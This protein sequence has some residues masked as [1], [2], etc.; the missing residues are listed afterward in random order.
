MQLVKLVPVCALAAAVLMIG[1]PRASASAIPC[2]YGAITMAASPTLTAPSPA[3]PANTIT[4]SGGS[5]S[6]GAP[7]TGF[8]KEWLRDGVV[9]AGPTW[10]VGPPGSFAYTVQSADVGHAIRSAV[11]PCND[12]V[13]C[14][15]SYA[16]S[17]NSVTP[18]SRPPTTGDEACTMFPT[19]AGC[20]VWFGT[21]DSDL[22]DCADGT[23]GPDPAHP[24]CDDPSLDTSVVAPTSC[25][26]DFPNC[27]CPS[28]QD[29]KRLVR[30][31]HNFKM[32]GTGIVV[33]YY[34]MRVFWCSNGASDSGR[35]TKIYTVYDH[36]I[37]KVASIYWH[38][39][40]LDYTS[41]DGGPYGHCAEQAG[42][43]AHPVHTVTISSKGRFQECLTIRFVF[44]HDKTL[45]VWLRIH[46]DMSREGGSL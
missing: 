23:L 26:H 35:I 2:V 34:G 44:C 32:K 5:W 36:H 40:G 45:G 46:R 42:D 13:G 1:S 8:W 6:C 21:E 3:Y 14:A 31:R 20:D 33:M 9:V 30:I 22:T 27:S 17:S 28:S 19:L 4:S 10:V 37:S 29:M 7:F 15:G 39:V 12:E 18:V 43:G 11:L 41:C 25:P 38:W 16:Q 24:A